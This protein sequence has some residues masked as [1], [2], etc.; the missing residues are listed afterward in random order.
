[1]KTKSW[2][3]GLASP[4]AAKPT[5]KPFTLESLWYDVNLIRQTNPL[6]HNITNWVVM[7]T[8]AN[9]LLAL[10]AS[11]IMA[12]APEEL[13]DIIQRAQAL[14]IN[15]GTL[16]ETCLAAIQKAQQA[17]LK[18]HIPIIFDPVGA[19]A[20]RYRTTSALSILQRGVDVIRG[21]ASEIM[22]LLD[23]SIITQGVDS[24]Q[25]SENALVSAKILA[26][27]YACVVV[28]SGKIDFIVNQANTVALDYGTPLLTKVVGMGCSLTAIIASFLAINHDHSQASI[29][30]MTWMGLMSEIAEKKSNGPG[31]FYAHLLD[32]FYTAQKNEIHSLLKTLI[33]V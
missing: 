18:Q 29:H 12:H 22:A 20:S 4:S 31:S 16:D 19:G 11:P 15:I 14:V 9:I 8:T 1:M 3:E 30:A 23:T 25:A 10:G 17:A 28:V 21:N 5:N 33:T 26:Q 24:S 32:S 27:Q 2:L 7:P 13:D 6:I